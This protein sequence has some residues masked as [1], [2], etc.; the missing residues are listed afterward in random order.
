LKEGGS[1]L[2]YGKPEPHCKQ[3]VSRILSRTAI[4]L[5]LPLLAGSSNLPG[6]FRS[7]T[8]CTILDNPRWRAGPARIRSRSGRAANFL[9]IWSCSVWGLPCLRRYRLSGALLPHLFTLTPVSGET[10]AVFSLWHWP[11]RGLD[12]A[13]PDVIRHTALRS[14]DFPLPV[15]LALGRQRPPGLPAFPMIAQF[16]GPAF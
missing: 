5:G 3:P 12:A 4:P 7:T 10:K 2:L 15:S 16:P 9:P 14:S 8:A 6:G 1:G 11:S 13:I